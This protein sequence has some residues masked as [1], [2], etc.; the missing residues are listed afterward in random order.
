MS[1]SLSQGFFLG[2]VAAVSLMAGVSAA[3]AGGFALR[4]QSAKGMGAAFAGA[5]AGGAGLSSMFWNPATMTDFSGLQT[6]SSFSVILPYSNISPTAATN[7]AL[8]LAGGTG[9]TGDIAQDAVVPASYAS[10][11]VSDQV[12][13]GI[14]IN[15]P[16]GLVT[17]NPN[18]W[19]GQIY[20]RTSKVFTVNANPNIAYKVNDWLSIGAGVQVQYFKVRLTQATGAAANAPSA[21]LKGDDTSLGFT[22]GAT[23]KPWA[24]GEI[25]IGYRSRVSP[26]LSGTLTTPLGVTDIRSDLTLPD[27]L[28]L[29][30]RQKVTQDFTVLGGFEWTHWKLFSRFPVLNTGGVAVTTLPFD[31]RNSWFASLGGEYAWNQNLTVRAGLG[32]EKSPITNATRSVRLPDS[33]RIWTTA[34]FTY[35]YN[36]KLS[37][38]VSYAHLFAKSGSINVVPGNPALLGPNFVAN[39]KS[40]VDIIS[41]GFTYR[42]DD[43]KPARAIVAKY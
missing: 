36:E 40:H 22:L 33:D 27:Q 34:G 41:V 6:S 32:F 10:Y 16:F 23:L 29:G 43:P 39:T 20:G 38:D 25:G 7:A 5:A 31:Y 8:L 1:R 37:L 3:T 17:Q 12:W 19:A 26:K 30:F 13:L 2:G 18:N 35:N 15:S 4:E 21:E 11:Q 42:W 28:T 9:S 14:G 24:G